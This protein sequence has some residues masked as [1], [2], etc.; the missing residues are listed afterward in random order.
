MRGC[1]YR[2]TELDLQSPSYR[3]SHHRQLLITVV[4]KFNYAVIFTS[5][6]TVKH[7]QTVPKR[8]EAAALG[9]AGSSENCG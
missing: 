8:T 1:C 2:T 3:P 7:K 9:H 5:G 6:D 4:R